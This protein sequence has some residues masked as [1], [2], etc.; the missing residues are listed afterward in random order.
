MQDHLGSTVGLSNAGGA[1][2]ESNSYDSFGNPAN[3]DF[4]SRYQFT[5]REFDGGTGLQYYAPAG[6]T[7]IS[8]GLFL[9][10][11]SGLGVE[12]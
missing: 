3:P 9:R 2:T 4:S 1:V 10:I 5:G 6:T 8:A 7:R 12:I 11:R